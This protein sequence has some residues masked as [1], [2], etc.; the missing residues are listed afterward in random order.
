MRGQWSQSRLFGYGASTWP[1]SGGAT[2]V[3]LFL[4]INHPLEAGLR[5][6]LRVCGHM[7]KGA[8]ARLVLNMHLFE[9]VP[10]HFR[11]LLFELLLAKQAYANLPTQEFVDMAYAECLRD[12]T[13]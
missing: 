10:A 4:Y 2:W 13:L 5:R 1:L 8:N 6:F 9:C 12:P 3:E 7:W 11:E